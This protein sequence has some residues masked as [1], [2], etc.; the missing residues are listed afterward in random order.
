MGPGIA[1][2][3]RVFHHVR[4]ARR[5]AHDD[6][7]RVGHHGIVMRRFLLLSEELVE[8]HLQLAPPGG[9]DVFEVHPPE[10]TRREEDPIEVVELL[11]IGVWQNKNT[12]AC[13]SSRQRL[14]TVMRSTSGR[15]W[16]DGRIDRETDRRSAESQQTITDVP[17]ASAAVELAKNPA[18]AGSVVK[19]RKL[20]GIP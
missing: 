11:E 19:S 1:A 17:S 2:D 13:A 20:V 14:G 6:L 4:C 15:G 12:P 3:Q 10:R 18:T 5:P 9:V 16:P 7:A 8:V